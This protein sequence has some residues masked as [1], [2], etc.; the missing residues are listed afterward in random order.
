MRWH[1]GRAVR[2]KRAGRFVTKKV[3]LAGDGCCKS[4]A[5]TGG[6]C[7]ATSTY[8]AG[9]LCLRESCQLLVGLGNV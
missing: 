8:G 5:R 4:A 9:E 2:Y 3:R 7:G 6:A 1:P